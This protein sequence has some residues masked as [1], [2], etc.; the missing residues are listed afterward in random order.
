M[1]KVLGLV[2][3]L[4]VGCAAKE[5][6]PIDPGGGGGGGGGS[7]GSD[8]GIDAPNDAAIDAPNIDAPEATITGHVCLVKDLRILAAGC[9]TSAAG[10]LTVTLGSKTTTTNDT[11]AFIIDKPAGSS[12]TWH[13]TG[14]GL[15]KSAVPF[16]P[17][18]TL[19]AIL[20]ADYATLLA[21][22]LATVQPGQGS[23]VAKIVKGAPVVANA[24]VSV[25]GEQGRQL[26]DANSTTTWAVDDTGPLGM[27]WLPGYGTGSRAV[28]VVPP[29][30]D[31]AKST[32]ITIEDQAITF[33][34]IDYAAL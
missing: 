6:F 24:T 5:D 13:V 30:P 12:L 8:A 26:Y 19:P 29:A 17:S 2:V 16:S 28:I 21:D 33:V 23:I 4:V 3:M 1:S 25:N 27:A 10:G 14:S 20:D 32:S 22:N 31:N 34:T 11:G 9:S 15:I 7:S 18:T